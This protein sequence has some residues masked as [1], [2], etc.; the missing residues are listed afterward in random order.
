[1]KVLAGVAPETPRSDWPA[2]VVR[3]DSLAG[4]VKK[5]LDALRRRNG[6]LRGWWRGL[7]G[8][9]D[10][11]PSVIGSMTEPNDSQDQRLVWTQDRFAEAV[12]RL[13]AAISGSV[14]A[15]NRILLSRGMTPLA[16][17][18]RGAGAAFP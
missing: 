15:L 9:F 13:D 7:I 14:P 8:E 5:S 2:E 1:V 12:N 6:D 10:G 3:A 4:E 18:S 16:V 11:G 17:P